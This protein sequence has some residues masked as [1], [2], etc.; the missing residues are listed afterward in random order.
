MINA[1]IVSYNYHFFFV[2]R[3]F[4]LYLPSNFQVTNTVLAIIIMLYF[5]FPELILLE[6]KSV[7]FDH[8]PSISPFLT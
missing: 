1:F 3:K 8:R 4:K 6:L 7:P 2:V 5:I